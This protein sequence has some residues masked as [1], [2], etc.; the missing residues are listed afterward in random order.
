MSTSN[1]GK[2][3]ETKFKTLV[4]RHYGSLANFCFTKLPD[5]YAGFKSAA[6]ADFLV[7]YAGVA[8][9]VEIKEVKHSFRLPKNNFSPDQI[10]RQTMWA[11]AGA[12]CWVLVYHSEDKLCRAV[13]ITE[14]SP[15][16]DGVGSWDLRAYATVDWETAIKT[17]L[18]AK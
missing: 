12:N 14:F 13:P 6:L 18:E 5:T 15:L 17:I 9:L 8:S 11:A 2:Y 10:A 4:G 1:R 3:A 7:M 16:P